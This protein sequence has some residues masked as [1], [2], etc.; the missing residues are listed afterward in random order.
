MRWLRRAASGFVL[1]GCRQSD[2]AALMALYEALGGAQWTQN[3][4]WSPSSDPCGIASRWFGVGISDPCDRWRDGEACDVGR[5]TS[6][7]LEQNNLNG[8]LSAWTQIGAL[9]NLSM[10]DLVKIMETAAFPVSK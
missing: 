6:L 9:T 5:V 3:E 10:V 8:D 1:A 4:N 7:Y 2:R